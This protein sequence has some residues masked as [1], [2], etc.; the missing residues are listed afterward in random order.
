VIVIPLAALV[1]LEAWQAF[2]RAPELVRSRELVTHAS[3]VIDSAQRLR[4]ALQDAERG[5]RGYLVTGAP[6]YL[7][8]YHSGSAQ[9]APRLQQLRELTAD[10]SEQ[11]ARIARLSNRI[12][13]KLSEMQQVLDTYGQS[14][15]A[16]AQQLV[17]TNTG[18]EAM[19]AIQSDLDE[20]VSSE[21]AL[22]GTRL[23]AL[24]LQERRTAA[25]AFV[26]SA[27]ALALLVIGVVLTVL[28]FRN[29]RRVEEQ[30]RATEQRL[31]EQLIRAQ[32]AAAQSQKME[33][34]GQLTGGVA[35]DF[36]NL[37]HVI[38][39]ALALLER[40]VRGPDAQI[41]GY[42]DMIKRNADRAASVTARLLAFSRRQALD[43]K[44]TD[45][46]KLVAGMAELLSHTLGEA[47]SLE[48]VRGAAV[49]PVAVDRNQLETAIVNL[50]LNAR[51]A[52]PAGGRLT[53]ETSNTYLDES[54]SGA[55]PEVQ[56]GQYAM[57]ALSDSGG[58]MSAEVAARA[59][60]PFFTTKEV[61]KGT[62]LGLSQVFGF[63]KQSGGHVKIYS[64]I[65][66][67]TTV[68]MYLPRLNGASPE[69]SD[70]GAFAPTLGAGESILVVEDHDDVRVFTTQILTALGYRVATAPDAPGALRLLEQHSGVDLLFTDV[71]LPGMGGR[72]L[73]DEVLRRWPATKVLY[74]T[75]YARNSIIHHGR[76]DPAVALITKPFTQAS[77]AAKVRAALE[78]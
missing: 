78:G 14:G 76:L 19:R 51:D 47:V 22:L 18:L 61:G 64:E 4:S 5:Q 2:G 13:V 35:H 25:L 58:G 23:E 69:P 45:V 53:I 1:A 73:A 63:I 32:A 57:I 21:R 72:A 17:R 27:L 40:R 50:A 42:L 6:A 7:E 77:L 43:P 16:A 41:N 67:G 11:Q 49:W 75:G 12:G 29:A 65:G 26:N 24:S 54:Y 62:G 9:S 37:L 28:A 34:L 74:T 33:S 56:E 30:R 46:N 71:G 44:P 39:N 3:Q 60:D 31:G 59:F 66:Q 68:K 55:H 15:F 36:N 70:A 8:A 48:M 20:I 52:M 10:N 38:N